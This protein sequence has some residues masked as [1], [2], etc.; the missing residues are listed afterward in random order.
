MEFFVSFGQNESLRKLFPMH[1]DNLHAVLQFRPEATHVLFCLL[2][3]S[4]PVHN[5]RHGV[6]HTSSTFILD[7]RKRFVY[8]IGKYNHCTYQ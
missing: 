4:S 1:R 3:F 8:I 2:A 7:K 6:H 5:S